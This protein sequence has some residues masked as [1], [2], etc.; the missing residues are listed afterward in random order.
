MPSSPGGEGSLGEARVAREQWGRAQPC[1]LGRRPWPL[2]A[3]ISP[4]S[5]LGIILLTS[6]LKK[7]LPGDRRG[8]GH[9]VAGLYG[10]P[11]EAPAATSWAGPTSGLK[12][13]TGACVLDSEVPTA[14]SP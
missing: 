2:W 6:I 5:T 3:S 4:T 9:G 11:T 10:G 1:D 7:Y 12:A 14:R 13:D 8:R